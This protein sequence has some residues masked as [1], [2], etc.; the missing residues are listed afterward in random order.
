MVDST[1]YR[2]F[3]A[4]PQGDKAVAEYVWL[5]GTGRDLR[6]KTRVLD[7]EPKTIED[8]PV[9][10]CDGSSCFY[11]EAKSKLIKVTFPMILYRRLA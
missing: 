5:G 1:L 6:S 9:W 2:S 11:K 4:L 8:V 7:K 3:L 10:T